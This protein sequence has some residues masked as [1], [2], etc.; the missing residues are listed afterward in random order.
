MLLTGQRVRPAVAEQ[1][2]Y[3]WRYPRLGQ[4]LSATVRH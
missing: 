4:A 2:G 3:D 1:L